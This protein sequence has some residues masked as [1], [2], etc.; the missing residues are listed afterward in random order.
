MCFYVTSCINLSIVS[1]FVVT[2]YTL[3]A[4][5][6]KQ[7]G[8]EGSLGVWRLGSRGWGLV[9]GGLLSRA[10]DFGSVTVHARP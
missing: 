5:D 1:L 8:F 2:N 7:R 9:A 4:K 3:T 6:P 10:T